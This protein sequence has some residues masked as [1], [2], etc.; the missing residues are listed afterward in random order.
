M[1]ETIRTWLSKLEEEWIDDIYNILLYNRKHPKVKGKLKI[2]KKSF[3]K[4]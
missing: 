4:D 2:L 3:L 1:E